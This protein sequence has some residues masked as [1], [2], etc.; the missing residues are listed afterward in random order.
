MKKQLMVGLFLLAVYGSIF[1]LS[2]IDRDKKNPPPPVEREYDPRQRGHY[3]AP[4]DYGDLTEE[5]IKKWN[6]PFEWDKARLRGLDGFVLTQDE[7]DGISKLPYGAVCPDGTRA[8]YLRLRDGREFYFDDIIVVNCKSREATVLRIDDIHYSVIWKLGWLN[9]GQIEFSGHANPSMDNYTVYDAQT[10]KVMRQHHGMDFTWDQAKE[11]MFYTR[12]S[13]HFLPKTA[14]EIIYM[15][16]TVIYDS[17]DK[18][19]IMGGLG[20]SQDQDFTFFESSLEG[21]PDAISQVYMV[22]G[23]FNGEKLVDVEKVLWD[24]KGVGFITV[25]DDGTLTVDDYYAPAATYERSKIFG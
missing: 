7:L 11:H 6:D 25:N 20:I 3:E 23:R 15:D 1:A 5:E 17:G 24:N 4:P 19:F 9:D 18:N 8:M 13:P 22:R 12:H 2:T 10:G 14:N 16:D 21:Y